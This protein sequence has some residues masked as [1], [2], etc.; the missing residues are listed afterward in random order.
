MGNSSSIPQRHEGRREAFATPSIV[1]SLVGKPA[2]TGTGR[3][4]ELEIAEDSLHRAERGRAQLNRTKAWR[5]D[6]TMLGT[7]ADL[8]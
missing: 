3:N 2:S 4:G 5:Y 7:N 6:R 1:A 8:K